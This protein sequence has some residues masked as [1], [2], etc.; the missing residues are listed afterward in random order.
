MIRQRKI[1]HPLYL[2]TGKEGSWVPLG[3][4]DCVDKGGKLK[5]YIIHCSVA[6][7]MRRIMVQLLNT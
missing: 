1:H 7:R 4:L 2:E 3:N 6:G 5:Y